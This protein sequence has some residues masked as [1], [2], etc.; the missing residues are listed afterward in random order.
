MSF[1]QCI[2]FLMMIAIGV[3]APSCAFAWGIDEDICY[4]KDGKALCV[5]ELLND[6]RTYAVFAVNGGHFGGFDDFDAGKSSGTLSS[7]SAGSEKPV[8][9]KWSCETA[10]GVTGTVTIGE[11]KFDLAKGNFFHVTFD[12]NKPQVK[13]LM[14]EMAK[15]DEG[16]TTEER[17]LAAAKTARE[18]SP[19]ANEWLESCKAEQGD[20]ADS[21]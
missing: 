5:F 20:A 19:F 2:A 8:E 17:L 6:D 16:A 10:D 15:Y 18:I 7:S 11:E 21:R 4:T 3:V 1:K 12:G 14:V 13:Q 9:I